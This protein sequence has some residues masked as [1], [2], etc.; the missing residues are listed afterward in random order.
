MWPRSDP[1]AAL[2]GSSCCDSRV[3][4]CILSGSRCTK[5]PC[6]MAVGICCCIRDFIVV[7]FKSDAPVGV[8]EM[9]VR[10]RKL[11]CRSGSASMAGSNDIFSVMLRLRSALS[12]GAR[13]K[14]YATLLFQF[15]KSMTEGCTLNTL[16]NTLVRS[17]PRFCL[18]FSIADIVV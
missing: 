8:A 11:P 3:A 2:S 9:K 1:A 16:A 10:W 13:Y 15:G 5:R 4:I 12:T 17:T 14:R 6:G 7:R 18:L